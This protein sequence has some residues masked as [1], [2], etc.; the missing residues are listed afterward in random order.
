M[1]LL[2]KEVKGESWSPDPCCC[3]ITCLAQ[4]EGGGCW[5][6]TSGA[7]LTSPLGLALSAPGIAFP[8]PFERSLASVSESVSSEMVSLTMGSN[9]PC[10][11]GSD[12]GSPPALPL[13]RRDVGGVLDAYFWFES[14]FSTLLPQPMSPR[15][16]FFIQ[17]KG[18]KQRNEVVVN[19]RLDR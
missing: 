12:L 14:P 2:L 4:D 7:N 3:V 6:F 18:R 17:G 10:A 9:S 8:S 13:W 5:D 19:G 15:L 11:S 1:A 16:L